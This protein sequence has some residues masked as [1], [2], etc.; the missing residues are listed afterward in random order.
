METSRRVIS[1][2]YPLEKFNG[3]RRKREWKDERKKMFRQRQI[4]ASFYA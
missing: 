1:K 2:P 4:Q 3:K